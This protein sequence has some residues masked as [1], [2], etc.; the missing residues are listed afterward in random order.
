VEA[1]NVY[2]KSR[3]DFL[4]K[5]VQERRETPEDIQIDIVHPGPQATQKPFFLFLF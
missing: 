3:A 1:N 4:D 5:L 2:L